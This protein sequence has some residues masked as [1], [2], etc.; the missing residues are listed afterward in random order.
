MCFL[1]LGLETLKSSHK[2]FPHPG[3]FTLDICQ[4]IFNFKFF[5]KMNFCGLNIIE[6]DRIITSF[7][8]LHAHHYYFLSV[9]TSHGG[10]VAFATPI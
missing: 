3:C 10:L 1:F 6:E 8:T 2:R 7:R 9:A 4:L 5:T